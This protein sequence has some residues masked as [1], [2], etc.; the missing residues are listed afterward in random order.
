MSMRKKDKFESK[1]FKYLEKKAEEREVSDPLELIIEF[2]KNK[3]FLEAA[4]DFDSTKKFRWKFGSLGEKMK[5]DLVS[6]WRNSTSGRLSNLKDIPNIT[7]KSGTEF[8]I[9]MFAEENLNIP[10]GFSRIIETELHDFSNDKFSFYSKTGKKLVLQYAV[11]PSSSK[12]MMISW[13]ELTHDF[14]EKL[15]I[16]NDDL[17][18][19][20]QSYKEHPDPE[21]YFFERYSIKN[22]YHFGAEEIATVSNKLDFEFE[23][24][25][26]KFPDDKKQKC[27][28]HDE[29][30]ESDCFPHVI[31][32]MIDVNKLVLAILLNNFHQES[33]R[34]SLVNV[35]KLPAQI[36]PVKCVILPLSTIDKKTVLATERLYNQFNKDFKTLVDDKGT[37]EMRMVRHNEIGVPFYVA[38]DPNFA[39]Q[40]IFWLYDNKFGTKAELSYEDILSYIISKIKE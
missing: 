12:D 27:F 7:I 3:E 20:C 34:T 16:P 6:S 4:E 29:L 13:M 35:M 17:E 5:S 22:I 28:V 2:L 8:L 11:V 23:N 25:E 33:L 39:D 30:R 9:E 40:N 37:L 1:G 36:A 19:E 24:Y 21:H 18:I 15:G 38:V 14:L 10:F 31:E 26:K 32:I